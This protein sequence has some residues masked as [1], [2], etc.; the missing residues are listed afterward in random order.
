MFRNMSLGM[1]I[2]GTVGVVLFLLAFTAIWSIV[3]LGSVVSNA[4]EVIEGN[5]LKGNIIQRHVDHLLWANQV[6]QLLTDDKVT[7]LNVQTDPHKCAF[8][9]W[10]YG[11]ERKKAEAFIPDLK[12]VLAEIEEPHNRLHASAVEIKKVF[13]QADDELG[14]FLYEK[15]GDHLNWMHHVKDALLSGSAS[16]MNVQM[17][18]SQCALGKWMASSEV[19]EIRKNNPQIGALLDKIVEPHRQLHES[20]V[21]IK[22]QLASGNVGAAKQY[23]KSVTEKNAL[24]T[25]GVIDEM[26]KVNT[27]EVKGMHM[28]HDIYANQ[29][30]KALDKV[31]ELLG[32]VVETTNDNVMTDD[33]MLH[34]AQTTRVTVIIFSLIAL[35]IGCLLAF[36]I[37][38]SIVRALTAIIANMRNG[39]E[40]VAAASEQLSSS[41]QSMSEGAS[42]QAS[43]LEEVS[44]SLEEMSS[45]TKQNADN[46][47]QANTLS[48]DTNAAAKEGMESMIR[49]SEVITKIKTSS[50][51]TAK[52]I[53][54]IDEIA[55]QTN[56]LA[57]NAAVE[58]AR[59]GDA[60]RGFAVVAEEVRNLAQRSADAAK[61]TASLIEGSQRNSEEGVE[62]SEAVAKTLDRIVNSVHKVTQLISEVSA[63]SSEQSQGIDQVNTAVAQ[64]DKVT[65][66]SAANAEESASASEELSSQAQNL[67]AMVEELVRLVGGTGGAAVQK[68]S[69]RILHASHAI[70][71]SS[72]RAAIA[73]HGG[74]RRMTTVPKKKQMVLSGKSVDPRQVIP[75]DD[76]AGLSE[77]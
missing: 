9:Q 31:G 73:H 48:E 17:D 1:K 59:A 50:D 6:N 28:A 47:R 51:E 22:Q 71:S 15:K 10:Y 30:V 63:A 12:N 33:Q 26:I 24:A 69:G 7:E 57:L 41:S 27:E 11:E 40:Q 13:H 35:I 70:S 16:D 36:F 49:M 18:P 44:S 39:S 64:M 34:A 4:T 5:K 60:G 37:S 67:N 19:A 29:T 20:A 46:A 52:I 65:Q 23:Y 77:F 62:A 2:G 54:T 55:M 58:A 75:M 76:D 45:M 74:D 25:L 14:A 68:P 72:D 32:K 53:K 61:N 66:S 8:G 43:S 21:T 56:L 3:G 42:E 38:S